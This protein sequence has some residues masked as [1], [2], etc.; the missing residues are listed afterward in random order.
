MNP[1]VET[2]T[3]NKGGVK[4]GIKTPGS[5]RKKGTPNKKTIDLQS[6]LEANG[7]DVGSEVAFLYNKAKNNDDIQ[8]MFQVL[9]MLMKYIYPQR[10]A[11][12][13]D[14]Q[15]IT[16]SMAEFMKGLEKVRK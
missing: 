5:G 9:N 12:E 15:E 6:K 7:I 11:I 1:K 16:N 14:T 3:V 10:K 13:M 4:G 2:K 8:M